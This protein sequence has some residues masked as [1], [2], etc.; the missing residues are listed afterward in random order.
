[1]TG[2]NSTGSYVSDAGKVHVAKDETAT[3]LTVKANSIADSTKSGK[4][5]ITVST[6]A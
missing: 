3:T 2:N 1:M 6:G 4:S 5:T